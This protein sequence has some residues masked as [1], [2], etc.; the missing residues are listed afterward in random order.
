VAVYAIHDKNLFTIFLSTLSAKGS[1]AANIRGLY[2][3]NKRS[4]Q[5]QRKKSL[6]T[7]AIYIHHI[8]SP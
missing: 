7:I 2:G 8:S 1:R 6:Q 5:N 4:R 3:A